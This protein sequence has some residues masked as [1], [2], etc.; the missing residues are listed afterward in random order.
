MDQK[1][2]E[3]KQLQ[4][5]KSEALLN[6]KHTQEATMALR[7]AN[8]EIRRNNARTEKVTNR[9]Q[10]GNYFQ[11]KEKAEIVE[12]N[13]YVSFKNSDLFN[14]SKKVL[15]HTVRATSSLPSKLKFLRRI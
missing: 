9:K 15:S 12:V 5:F 13:P 4:D 3:R 11:C 7:K 1:K 2:D 10:N 8:A 14:S 6:I